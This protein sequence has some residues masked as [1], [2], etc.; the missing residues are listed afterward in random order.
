MRHLAQ[1]DLATDEAIAEHDF[2][3]TRE[4]CSRTS[5]DP[6]G[7]YSI[8]PS[9]SYAVGAIDVFDIN[10][11]NRVLDLDGLADFMRQTV[12]SSDGRVALVA[13]GG[14]PQ[15]LARGAVYLIDLPSRSFLGSYERHGAWSIAAGSDDRVYVCAQYDREGRGR[16]EERGVD[17][18]KLT[19]GRL[20]RVGF[21]Y[22]I[23]PYYGWPELVVKKRRG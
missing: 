7:T 5:V 15:V 11:G 21:F 20:A 12:F 14:N 1:L 2:E 8:C 6:S 17:V 16:K 10:T 19:E 18:L 13:G 4:C 22:M 23:S 3:V 9:Y